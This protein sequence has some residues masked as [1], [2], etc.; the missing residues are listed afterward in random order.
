M[1]Y[2]GIQTC[3]RFGVLHLTPLPVT[4]FRDLG[5]QAKTF[6]NMFAKK[7]KQDMKRLDV[8]LV[9]LMIIHDVDL[10]MVLVVMA[11]VG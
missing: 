1:V 10:L 7:H 6:R 2:T 4:G 11:L 3:W 9:N 8:V 5:P